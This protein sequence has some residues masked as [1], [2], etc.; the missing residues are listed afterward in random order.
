LLP[1]WTK[2]LGIWAKGSAW[3]GLHGHYWLGRLAAVNTAGV[4]LARMSRRMRLDLGA[5]SIFVNNGAAAS[6]Y[7]SIA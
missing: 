5:T 1:L 6:E 2:A 3:Y 7:Y 4:I